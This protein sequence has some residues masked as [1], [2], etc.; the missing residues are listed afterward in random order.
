MKAR[1]RLSV[2]RDD[3][4]VTVIR[5]LRSAAPLTLMPGPPGVVHLVNS[6]AAPLAGDDLELTVRVGPGA[7]LALRGVAASLALP[8]HHFEPSRFAVRLEV[9]GDGELEYLPEPTV[10]TGRARHESELRA[11]VDPDARLR[12]REVLVLGRHGERPGHLSSTIRLVRGGRPVLSQG[13][14]IGDPALDGSLAHLAGRRVLA[15]EI[16]L[17]N[18]GLPTPRSEEWWSLTP[19]GEGGWIATA[20]ADAVTTALSCLDLACTGA[21]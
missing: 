21:D 2:E 5:E 10:I 15:T 16:R 4:G 9:A 12:C 19:L 17:S 7:R 13:L 1:A 20:L 14:A 18:S 6:A 8:G 11:E 3:R